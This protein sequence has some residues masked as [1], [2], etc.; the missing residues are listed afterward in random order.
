MLVYHKL[1]NAHIML[2]YSNSFS[3]STL[4]LLAREVTARDSHLAPAAA[5]L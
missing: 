4:C 5:A 2:I 1:L 3:Q